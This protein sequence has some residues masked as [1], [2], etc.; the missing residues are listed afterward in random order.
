MKCSQDCHSILKL[1]RRYMKSKM[2]ILLYSQV[3]LKSESLFLPSSYEKYR[4]IFWYN[5]WKIRKQYLLKHILQ[6]YVKLNGLKFQ[7]GP[8]NIQLHKLGTPNMKHYSGQFTLTTFTMIII[9]FFNYLRHRSKFLGI[10]CAFSIGE[11]RTAYR[12]PH[13]ASSD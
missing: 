5:I 4:N 8:E 9:F 6:V 11:T 1:Y 13:P 12:I 3:N 7:N 10:Q 2:D